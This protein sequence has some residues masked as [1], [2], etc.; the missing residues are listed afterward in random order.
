MNDLTIAAHTG[1]FGFDA[2]HLFGTL[3][4]KS[5]IILL[6][7][8]TVTAGLRRVSASLRQWIWNL[9]VVSLLVLALA[10]TFAPIWDMPFVPAGDLAAA[11]S[12]S[13]V[14]SQSVEEQVRL[15]PQMLAISM[16]SGVLTPSIG[17]FIVTVL[18]FTWVAGFLFFAAAIVMDLIK[19]RLISAEAEP[20]PDEW[21]EII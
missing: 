12:I 18:L 19:L 8:I 10:S 13:P 17:R 14:Y 2:I 7:V 3:F 21:R 20:V 5:S 16:E 6:L 4:V 9:A 1:L 15:F 11:N